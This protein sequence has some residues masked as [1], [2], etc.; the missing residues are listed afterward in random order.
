MASSPGPSVDLGVTKVVD[1][2]TPTPGEVLTYTI[3][4]SVRCT[5]AAYGTGD[6]IVAVLTMINNA[7]PTPP[8]LD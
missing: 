8:L 5:S 2:P 3:E 1:D 7:V 6:P 4:V